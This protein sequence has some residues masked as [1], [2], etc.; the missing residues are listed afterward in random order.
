MTYKCGGCQFA[1]FCSE[2]CIKSAYLHKLECAALAKLSLQNVDGETGPLRLL[3]RLLATNE[4]ETVCSAKQSVK[5]GNYQAM[6]L[7]EFKFIITS[8]CIALLGYNG[9]YFCVL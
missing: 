3:L 5:P 4:H 9:R 1:H 7:V 2:K 6:E 8:R